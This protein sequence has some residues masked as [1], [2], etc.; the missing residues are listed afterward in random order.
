MN[1]KLTG[2]QGEKR[3]SAYLESKGFEI[4]E[5]NWRTNRGELDIIAVKNDI[6]VFVEVKTLPNGTLDMIQREL[7]NQKRQRIIK[8]SKRFLLKHREYNNSYVR[9]D[10]IVIDM[11][12]L[13]PVY[14]I[15]NAFSE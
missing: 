1:T 3:A 2:N 8:T 9:F 15:E 12:G 10:V 6:L 11:P 13:E 7:N 5:R 14:H 4:I